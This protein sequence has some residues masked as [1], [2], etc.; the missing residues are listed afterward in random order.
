MFPI[1][2]L[3]FTH[4]FKICFETLRISGEK[5]I[6]YDTIIGLSEQLEDLM[7]FLRLNI[8][9]LRKILKKARKRFRLTEETLFELNTFGNELD[10]AVMV[11][12]F[13][14]NDMQRQLDVHFKTRY[15]V[16]LKLNRTC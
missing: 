9:A 2:Y 13:G 6:A 12:A 16:V 14:L 8:T 15:V 11:E 5:K 4:L 3:Y 10:E 1:L 7:E